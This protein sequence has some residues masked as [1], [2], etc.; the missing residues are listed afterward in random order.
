MP[1]LLQYRR[2]MSLLASVAGG[3]RAS[4]SDNVAGFTETAK[5]GSSLIAWKFG[6]LLFGILV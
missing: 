4:R 5:H 2:R 6:Y 3:G 1:L